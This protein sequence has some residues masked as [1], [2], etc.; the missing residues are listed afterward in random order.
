MS[1]YPRPKESSIS[2]KPY[3]PDQVVAGL[4]AMALAMSMADWIVQTLH[5]PSSVQALRAWLWYYALVL[6]VA[7]LCLWA[8]YALARRRLWGFV[9]VLVTTGLLSVGNATYGRAVPAAV[10]FL[11]LVY[12]ALRA[13]G[14]FGPRPL[15]RRDLA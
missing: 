2:L 10:E 15:H 12:A 9:T 11:L 1:D 8:F 5:S 3:R 13:F 7:V 6:L 4:Y 14:F